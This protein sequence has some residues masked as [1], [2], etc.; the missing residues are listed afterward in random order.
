MG[1]FGCMTAFAGQGLTL[2]AK[3]TVCRKGGKTPLK[4]Y[5]RSAVLALDVGPGFIH[6]MEN[7][8]NPALSSFNAVEGMRDRGFGLFLVSKG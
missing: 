7:L 3:T 5:G 8:T 1:R 2:K 6:G 4:V